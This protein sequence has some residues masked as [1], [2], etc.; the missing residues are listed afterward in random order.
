MR[1]KTSDNDIK[2]NE[3]ILSIVQPSVCSNI[4]GKAPCIMY[5]ARQVH[6][7]NDGKV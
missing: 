6:Y 7:T 3:S 2:K 1:Q 4:A 5:I